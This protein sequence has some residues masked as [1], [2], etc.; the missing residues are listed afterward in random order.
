M[1]RNIK[2]WIYTVKISNNQLKYIENQNICR[3]VSYNKSFHVF[4]ISLKIG[5]K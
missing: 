4:Y 2:S 5:Y 1:E 3:E